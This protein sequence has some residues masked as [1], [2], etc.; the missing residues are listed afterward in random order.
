MTDSK[1]VLT[2]Q[3]LTAMINEIKSPGAFLKNLLFS[4]NVETLSTEKIELSY[5]SGDREVA[6]FVR[7]NGEAIPIE[8]YSET[9]ATVEAPNIRLKRPLT[10]HPTLFDRKPGTVIFPSSGEQL[11]AVQAHVARDMQKIADH[12]SNAEEWMAA[13]AIRGTVSYEVEDGEVFTI[14]YPK[15]AGNSV[16]VSPLWSTT[17]YPESDF[18]TA[19]EL[20]SDGVGLI[21]TDAIMGRNAAA[22]FIKNARVLSLLDNRRVDYGALQ[23]QEQFRDDGA[24]YMGM[25]QGIR[26]WRYG[27]ALS[28]NG[29]ATRLI[30]DDYVEFVCATPA[31]QNVA[32]YG[33]IPDWKAFA[34]GKFQGQRF[35][36]SWEEDDPSIRV[37]LGHSRP[38]F[39]PRRPGSLVS[40]KVT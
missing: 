33:A 18:Q 27:R 29:T 32:Y 39:V 26:C 22:A 13:M 17:S 36:K 14:T 4:T 38:L 24:L 25:L 7:K 31:A 21:P 30:R 15:P 10:P 16:T 3:S 5:L 37:L 12:I 23:L 11:S 35:S 1:D 8:G 19:A 20:I 34:E 9:Y 40:L 28:V 2:W 6:P